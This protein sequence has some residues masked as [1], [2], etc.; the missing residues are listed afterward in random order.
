MDGLVC[1]RNNSEEKSPGNG[2]VSLT[3]GEGKHVDL[4]GQGDGGGEGSKNAGQYHRIF[5]PKVAHVAITRL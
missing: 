5:L 3:P 1:V 4:H 2:F